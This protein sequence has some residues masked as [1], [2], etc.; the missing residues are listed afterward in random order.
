M[1]R[2][3]YKHTEEAKQKMSKARS[4]VNNPMYG[5]HRY[6]KDAPMYG[7][8]RYGK[9]N[10]MYGKK[11]SEETKAKMRQYALGKKVSE[12]TK[13]KISEAFKG[14]NHPMYGK[15][16]SE[17]TKM[18]LRQANL[19]KKA[20]EETKMKLSK[21]RLGKFAGANN[22]N[23]GKRGKEAPMYGKTHSEETREKLR[24][25][26]SHQVFPF[27]DSK[28]EVKLQNELTKNKVPFFKHKS[29]KMLDNTRHQVD[30][31]VP[32]YLCIEADGEYWH[33]LPKKKKRDKLINKS[34]EELG[35]KVFRFWGND[36]NSDTTRCLNTMTWALI[37][38]DREALDFALSYD[39]KKDNEFYE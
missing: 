27:K 36:I 20:S 4:G 28:L 10:P 19:G 38:R 29:F 23:Y 22:P 18:K 26:R 32:D 39:A 16:H 17:E 7:V 3:G 37:F 11:H 25:A 5:V 8:H 14:E 34:L 21:M 2:R 35:F 12:E 30:L 31:F 15:H 1:P 24:E 13:K 6:G 9:E 33:N